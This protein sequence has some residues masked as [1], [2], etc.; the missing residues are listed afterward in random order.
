MTS[1]KA[2]AAF[3]ATDPLSKHAAG[4]RVG[5]GCMV[6]SC[7]ECENEPARSSTASNA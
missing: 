6:N 7:R 3:S 1:V 5:V 4:D 2:Y